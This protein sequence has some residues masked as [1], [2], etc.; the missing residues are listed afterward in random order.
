MQTLTTRTFLC[1]LIFISFT[2]CLQNNG[3]SAQK[4]NKKPC[5]NSVQFGD[6]DVCLPEVA[7]VKECH[8]DSL[9]KNKIAMIEMAN[10]EVIGLY[11]NNRTYKQIEQIDQITYDDYF[12][13]Y[14]SKSRKNI[15]AGKAELDETYG[16]A[17]SSFSNENW[18]KVND[19]IK[20]KTAGLTID[21][22]VLIQ[23]YSPNDKI[24][25]ALLMIQVNDLEEVHYMVVTMN[26][27]LVKERI[28]FVAYYRNYDGKESIKKCKSVNDYFT[29]KLLGDN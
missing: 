18:D 23:S 14:I 10:T 13:V 26:L 3:K 8:R 15:K 2:G 24:R 12:S 16:Y 25:T 11:L 1:L 28:I 6:I 20:E 4:D 17:V 29:F 22:P 19:M 21:K 5:N 27:M 7:G 9:M